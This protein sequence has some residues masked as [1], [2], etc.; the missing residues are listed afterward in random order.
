[1]AVTISPLARKLSLKKATRALI[2]AMPPGYLDLLSPLPEDVTISQKVSGHYPF[3]QLFAS[4]K[5]DI[6]KQAPALLAHAAPDAIV[7]ITYPKR[8]SGVTSDLSREEVWDAM[9][10]FGWRPVSAVSI[11]SIWSG[12]RFRPIADVKSKKRTSSAAHP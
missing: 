8:T 7:W 11:D 2:L 5:A 9:S 4:Q 1:M 3:I 12:L 10:P 6:Q